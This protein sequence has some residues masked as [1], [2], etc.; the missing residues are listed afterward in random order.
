M[1]QVYHGNYAKYF[2]ISRTN[3]LK[4]IRICDKTLES[5]NIIIPVIEMSIRYIKPVFYDDLIK[6]NTTLQEL[7]GIRLLFE[8][9]I[10]S[11]NNVIINRANST[12]VFVDSR[13]QKPIRIPGEIVSKLGHKIKIKKPIKCIQKI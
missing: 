6:I 2:Y 13:I 1:E 5:Q 9:L 4:K 7:S 8:H 3:L 10:Y 12:M 11:A